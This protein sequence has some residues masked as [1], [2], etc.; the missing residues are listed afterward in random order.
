MIFFGSYRILMLSL[1]ELQK[2]ERD[3]FKNSISPE[4]RMTMPFMKV[5][6]TFSNLIVYFLIIKLT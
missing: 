2:F 6:K 1:Y 4:R 3:Q 5:N